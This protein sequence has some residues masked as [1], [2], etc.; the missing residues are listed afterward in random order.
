MYGR[1]VVCTVL[2]RDNDALDHMR[3]CQELGRNP[4]MEG[5]ALQQVGLHAERGVERC[6]MCD[7]TRWRVC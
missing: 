3:T 5:V 4:A 1:S 7:R 6:L 2:I